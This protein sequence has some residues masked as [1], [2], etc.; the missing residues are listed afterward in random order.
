[1][2]ANSLVEGG[3]T[4]LPGGRSR[5]KNKLLRAFG[6]KK[7]TNSEEDR[8]SKSPLSPAPDAFELRED[9]SYKKKKKKSWLKSKLKFGKATRS[10]LTGAAA[11]AGEMNTQ[12]AIPDGSDLIVDPTDRKSKKLKFK[13]DPDYTPDMTLTQ[14]VDFL[15]EKEGTLAKQLAASKEAHQ[16]FT[17]EIKALEIEILKIKQVQ[18]PVKQALT[19]TKGASD[20]FLEK[21]K[22]INKSIVHA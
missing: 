22:E 21:Q 17:A 8:H 3:S 5:S 19:K 4:A 12:Y 11:M 7:H 20:E 10:S 1:M 15:S 9:M 13:P 6:K 2:E 16:T 18:E 14:M